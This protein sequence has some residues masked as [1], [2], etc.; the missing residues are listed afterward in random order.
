MKT[1]NELNKYAKEINEAIRDEPDTETGYRSFSPVMGEFF[2]DR[3]HPTILTAYF[4]M[5]VPMSIAAS[6]PLSKKLIAERMLWA[7]QSASDLL[8]K[9]QNRL[10]KFLEAQGD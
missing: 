7:C 9:H 3:S 5:A 1:I 6:E 10:E 4:D 8:E 2:I